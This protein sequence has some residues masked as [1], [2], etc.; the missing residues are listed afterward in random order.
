MA[1]NGSG[2][3]EGNA[4]QARLIEL[5]AVGRAA[6]D[7]KYGQLRQANA[8][9]DQLMSAGASDEDRRRTELRAIGKSVSAQRYGQS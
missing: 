3:D 1:S 5:R 8:K 9:A 4:R 7:R 6:M 2:K